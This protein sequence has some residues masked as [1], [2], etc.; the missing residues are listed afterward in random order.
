MCACTSFRIAS[1]TVVA[2]A[3]A[4]YPHIS[5]IWS[6]QEGKPYYF[7]KCTIVCTSKTQDKYIVFQAQILLFYTLYNTYACIHYKLINHWTV[8]LKLLNEK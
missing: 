2:A 6:K 4:S 1:V 5:F 8:G 3:A 7:I